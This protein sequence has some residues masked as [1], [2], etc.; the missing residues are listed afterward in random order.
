MLGRAFQRP[1]VSI[2]AAN[3]SA[4]REHAVLGTVLNGVAL[5]DDL[6]RKPE[7]QVGQDALQGN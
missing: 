5:L 7:F 1:V 2:L 6:Q 3:H 4:S